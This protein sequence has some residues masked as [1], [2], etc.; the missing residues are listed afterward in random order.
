MQFHPETTVEIVGRWAEADA[1]RL[2]ALGRADASALIAASPE[3]REAARVAAFA[4]FDGFLERAN[5][6][7][8]VAAAARRG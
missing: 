2:A 7:A 5:D 6:P 3:R 1:E 8:V 4:L